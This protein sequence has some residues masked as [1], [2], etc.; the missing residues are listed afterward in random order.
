MEI[1]ILVIVAAVVLFLAEGFNWWS[2]KDSE[3]RKNNLFRS[4]FEKLK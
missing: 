3:A 1:L 2:N 4:V